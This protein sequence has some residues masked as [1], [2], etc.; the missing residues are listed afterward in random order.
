MTFLYL[1]YQDHCL[2]KVITHLYCQ[3][4]GPPNTF[5]GQ[6]LRCGCSVKNV[7]KHRFWVK[8]VEHNAFWSKKWKTSILSPN[9]QKIHFGLKL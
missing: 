4:L 2:N 9:R 6:N 5:R 7:I 3:D 8:N 1:H